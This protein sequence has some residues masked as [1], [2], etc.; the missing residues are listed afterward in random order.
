V[1]DKDE[2]L[3]ALYFMAGEGQGLDGIDKV[4]RDA[5]DLALID[6]AAPDGTVR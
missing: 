5:E 4:T 6:G 1:P 2:V 3:G